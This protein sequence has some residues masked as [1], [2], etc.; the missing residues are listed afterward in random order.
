MSAHDPKQTL[1]AD[2]SRLA[3]CGALPDSGARSVSLE[4]EAIRNVRQTKP[5]GPDDQ[6]DNALVS[7]LDSKPAAFCS[8]VELVAPMCFGGH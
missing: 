6:G 8:V 1:E 5:V 2:H 4:I 3:V 7:S